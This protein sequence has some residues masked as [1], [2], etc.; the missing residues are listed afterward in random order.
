[1]DRQEADLEILEAIRNKEANAYSR[2]FAAYEDYVFA[3]VR[4]YVKHSDIA[5]DLVLE[6]FTKIFVNL[7]KYEPSGKFSSW[8]GTLCRNHVL[9]QLRKQ[10]SK[11]AQS[12]D[13][14]SAS[15]Q[16]A[17]EDKDPL[18][19]I[20]EEERNKN[21]DDLIELLKPKYRELIRLRYFDEKSYDEIA[22]LKQLPLGT[23]KAQLHRSKHL[24]SEMIKSIK[25]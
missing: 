3:I 1:M 13:D 23:V 8:L 24:L 20:I 6:C 4:K 17:D 19:Q 14:L 16:L 9:D 5:D 7:E 21:L 10:K 2:L 25:K 11:Q 22:E 12:I 15:L 18:Q